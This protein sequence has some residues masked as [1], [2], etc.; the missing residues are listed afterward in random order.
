[1]KHKT[2]S[3]TVTKT[4]DGFEATIPKLKATVKGSTFDE[5]VLEA[6]K[7]LAIWLYKRDKAKRAKR[8][9]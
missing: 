4:A 7:A 8:K 5:A 1:M 6:E 3:F 2:Y 9:K